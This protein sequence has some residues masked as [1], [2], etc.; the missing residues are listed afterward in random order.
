MRLDKFLADA[1]A[2][3]RS[4]VKKKIR[5]G[6]VTVN[7][8]PEKKPE[9]KVDPACDQIC[10]DQK[11]V[12]YEAF[13]YYLFYKPAGCVTARQDSRSQTV[14][15][16]FPD[17]LRKD[18]APV[19]RLDKDTEGLL[20]VTNDG[21]LAHRL[22]S[23]AYHVKKTY[24]VQTDCAI[25]GDTALKFAAGIAIGDEKPTLPATLRML[26]E[27]EAELTIAEGR[28]HQVKRMFAAVGCQ[29][30]YLKR[31]TMGPLVLGDLKKGSY[32]KL[33]EAEVASLQKETEN[34]QSSGV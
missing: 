33:T 22:L 21:V 25:P 6:R 31:L 7:A 23:P 29:V 2:G 9:Y 3:T 24:Y 28:F 15:D 32:R 20:L 8:V 4:D 14:M 12:C 19:G 5:Q 34:K 27:Q 13:S 1:G 26:G 17:A 11:P 16:F 30:T 10:L 18:C